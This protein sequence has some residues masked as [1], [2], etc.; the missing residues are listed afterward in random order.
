M[1]EEQDLLPLKYKEIGKNPKVHPK[2]HPKV[3]LSTSS[4][5]NKW[6][7]DLLIKYKTVAAT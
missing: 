1:L 7:W 2:V 6:W 5:S 4:H 3:N